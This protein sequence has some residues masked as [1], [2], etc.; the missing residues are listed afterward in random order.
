MEHAKLSRINGFTLVEFLVSIV[1]L[2]VGL[3]GLLQAI[4]YSIGHSM[5]T[6]LRDEA[7]MLADERMAT[8]KSKKFDAIQTTTESQVV[9]LAVANGFKNYS[10]VKSAIDVTG[11]TKTVQVRVGWRYKGRLYSHV[12]SSLVAKTVH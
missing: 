7:V 1:I 12:I 5:N 8:E 10:V 11:N 2:S 4:N 6:R 3:L 9:K